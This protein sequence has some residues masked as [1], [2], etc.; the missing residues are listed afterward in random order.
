[1][2]I[3]QRLAFSV[4]LLG[5]ALNVFA[6]TTDPLAG[7]KELD[8][9]Q[10]KQFEDARTSGKRVDFNALQT[11]LKNKALAMVKGLDIKKIDPKNAYN[12]AQLFARADLNKETCALAEAYIKKANPSAADKFDAQ[13]LMLT[14]C[15]EMKEA[16]MLAEN[17]PN[18]VPTDDARAANLAMMGS[19]FTEVIQTAQGPKK[20]LKA[21]DAVE[22]NLPTFTDTSAQGKTR[23]A[24]AKFSIVDRR[25]ELLVADK[26]K[27]EA[28]RVLKDF[29]ATLDANSPILRTVKGSTTRLEMLDRAAPTF[30]TERGYGE[31]AGIE[32]LKGKVV[33][34]D[35]FA[36]WC[37]PCIA[38][39]PEMKELLKELQ[40]KGLEIIGFTTYYGYYKAE[41]REKRDM[42][43]D[44]EFAKMKDFIAEQTLPWPVVYGERSV[45]ETYGVTGIPHVAVIDRKGVLRKIK[46]GYSPASFGEFKKFVQE[47]LDEK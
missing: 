3:I 9:Y 25:A 1:M 32:S 36:H 27:D 5:A 23:A 24:S 11:E 6:Q 8:A 10:Q 34:V 30:A 35:F 38:A 31:F 46:I 7:L 17:L 44:V 20:A 33:L 2:R 26:R 13:M 14:A 12:W 15:N 45:F 42:P 29:S 43:K 4:V 18:V 47:L 40:P 19:Y 41:N 39:F 22:K 16:G 28:I 37:G 21:L